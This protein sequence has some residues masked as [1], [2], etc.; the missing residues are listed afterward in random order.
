M[1]H[2]CGSHKYA[3]FRSPRFQLWKMEMSKGLGCCFEAHHFICTEA[4]GCSWPASALSRDVGVG[5]MQG[6]QSP[7][8]GDFGSRTFNW[9]Y[10]NFL[11]TAQQSKAFAIQAFFLPSPP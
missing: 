10:Q 7:L 11:V 3:S 2:V 5:V 1:Y 4:Q 6:T 9:L 8:N